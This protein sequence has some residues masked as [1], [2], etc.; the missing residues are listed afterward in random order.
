MKLREQSVTP[1]PLEHLIHIPK[2]AETVNLKDYIIWQICF[3]T[4]TQVF[5]L[6]RQCWQNFVC[7]QT[8]RN[9]IDK[10]QNE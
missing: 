5:K 9:A 8:T 2:L 3:C 6:C 4:V 1:P 7:M 10:M